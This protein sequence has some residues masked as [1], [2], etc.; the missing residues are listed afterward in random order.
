MV[1][2]IEWYQC[3]G[4]GRRLKWRAELVGRET[5]CQCG[6]V[7]VCPELSGFELE[8]ASPDSTMS[9]TASGSMSGSVIAASQQE[10][11]EVDLTEEVEP[12]RCVHGEIPWHRHINFKAVCWTG[13]A[14]FGLSVGIFA[15]IMAEW[16]W[17]VAAVIITPFTFWKWWKC[18]R[19]WQGPRS[20]AR[21]VEETLGEQ[22]AGH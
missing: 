21:A 9:A 1:E 3:R 19:I 22:G 13:A 12:A 11:L 18:E 10:V 14:L 6:S 16:P 8:E 15:V 4:C 17:I 5:E 7:V 20:L 2:L